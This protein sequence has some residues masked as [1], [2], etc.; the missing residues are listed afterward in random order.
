M[1]PRSTYG[2]LLVV[3][4]LAALQLALR[5][6]PRAEA[7]SS[8]WIMVHVASDVVGGGDWSFTA[9][10][11]TITIDDPSTPQNPDYSETENLVNQ[12]FSRNVGAGIDVKPG[13]VVTVGDGTNT[14]VHVVAGVAI[15]S[16]D[17]VAD[18]VVG[19]ATPG[20]SVGV[21]IPWHTAESTTVAD[22]S[23]HWVIDFTGVWDI[24]GGNW[25]GARE[26]DSDGDS[27]VV[28]KLV[29]ADS[30]GDGVV[31]VLDNCPADPNTTQYD[32]DDDDVGAVCDD[33]DRI[34]GADRYETSAA[35][36]RMAF[37]SANTVFLASGAKFP[38]ALVA[39]AAGGNL[40]APVLLT[41]KDAL[42]PATVAE[43]TRLSP[44]TVYIAGGTAV[45]SAAV[46]QQVAA[47]GLSV[48]RL[49]GANR[50]ETAGEV[51]TTIFPTATAIIVASG[52]NFPDALVGAVAAGYHDYPVLLTGKDHVPQATIDEVQRLSPTAI[53]IIGGTAAVSEKVATEL[54]AYTSVFRYA[55]PDRYAT[56]A[57]VAAKLLPVTN[58][59]FLAS[60][61][62]FPDALVAAAAGAR[63]IG[64]VLLV[65][66]HAVPA[67]TKGRLDAVTPGH[68]WIVGGTAVIGQDVFDALP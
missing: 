40:D 3:F 32:G 59:V 67:A 6:A 31:N 48:K 53:L 62:N 41:G 42:P 38:D 25:V 29:L 4:V 5:G 35:V 8:P 54:E 51:S 58:R 19:T 14:K 34:W 20:A 37:E 60:G 15:S 11:V 23:G 24:V 28:R 55:G 13:H 65:K 44:S 43:L 9:P 61:E 56:A 49:A 57:A 68:I 10:D 39:A 2:V 36:S 21:W 27:T 66:H 45:V 33:V 50:Y 30:D 64:P 47:L 17:Q 26:Y 18:T 52:E 12:S 22:G 1:T 46:E 63:L 7:A 16:I